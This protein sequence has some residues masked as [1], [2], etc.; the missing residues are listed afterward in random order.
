MPGRST[1]VTYSTTD[2]KG[3]FITFGIYIKSTSM[4][5]I[6]SIKQL[7]KE[8]KSKDGAFTDFFVLLNYG[9]KSSKKISYNPATKTFDVHNEIDDS[10]QEDL[11]EDQLKEHTHII[12]AIEKR[13]LFKYD[14]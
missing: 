12:D 5:I 7:K 10:Y 9:L 3:H 13:A 11:T 2:Y 8:A 14:Q 6:N 4:K 1:N